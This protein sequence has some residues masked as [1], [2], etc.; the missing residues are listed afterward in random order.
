MISTAAEQS[1]IDRLGWTFEDRLSLTVVG[2]GTGVFQRAADG[3]H[4]LTRRGQIHVPGPMRARCAI[5]K[6]DRLPLA[7][8]NAGDVLVFHTMS[9]LDHWLS[10]ENER[11]LRGGRP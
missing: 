7:A 5:T 10:A 2:N 11:A 6:G 9:Q 4:H 8:L 3:W 1:I